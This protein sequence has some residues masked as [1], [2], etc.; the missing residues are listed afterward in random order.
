MVTMVIDSAS[1]PT[2]ALIE[3]CIAMSGETLLSNRTLPNQ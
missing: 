3:N 1:Q 2:G